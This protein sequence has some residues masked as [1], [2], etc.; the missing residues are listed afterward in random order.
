MPSRPFLRTQASGLTLSWHP[1]NGQ[2]TGS[3]IGVVSDAVGRDAY[4]EAG[5]YVAQV[6]GTAVYEVNYTPDDRGRIDARTETLLG[7]THSYEYDYDLAGRLTDVRR[8]GVL[9]AHYDYD[10]SGNRL[11]RTSPGGTE[12]GAYDDQDRILSY[13]DKTYE[14]TPAGDVVSVTDTSTNVTSTFS[15]DARGNLRQAVL[16]SG[17]VIDYLVDGE[18]HRVWKKKNGVLVQGFLYRDK[19]RP[20]AELNATGAVVARFVYGQE[21]NVPD[22]I[23]KGAATYRLLTDHRGSPRLLVDTATGAVAQRIDYDEFGRVLQDTNPGFQPFGFAGGLYDLD[24]KLVRFGA[25]GYDAESGRWRSKDPILFNGG[26]SNLYGY[27][28]SDPINLADPSGRGPKEFFECILRGRPPSECACEEEQRICNGPAGPYICVPD[29]RPAGTPGGWL[30]SIRYP[31]CHIVPPSRIQACCRVA[32]GFHEEEDGL[33]EESICRQ[34]SDMDSD[35]LKKY[36]EY[37]FCV[38]ESYGAN[39]LLS[40]K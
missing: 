24:T 26:D 39:G 5:T 3:S 19:L 36:T 18:H 7:D 15:Y 23:I 29:D 37:Q 28:V 25:R 13:G 17:D 16:G 9:V 35:T 22:L 8:D 31:Q 33:D 38:T 14:T 1:Q 30:P 27:V 12:S 40:H 32:T 6:G 2:Y 34:A 11:A 20:V 10:A 21:R 4:G